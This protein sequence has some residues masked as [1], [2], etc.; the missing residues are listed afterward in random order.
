M[1]FDI[2][3]GCKNWKMSTILL[4]IIHVPSFGV[5]PRVV[6]WVVFVQLLKTWHFQEG[7][8]FG[9]FLLIYRINFGI[10]III[11]PYSK[12]VCTKNIRYGTPSTRKGSFV[13]VMWHI[14]FC[15]CIM[16]YHYA[17]PSISK[18][19]HVRVKYKFCNGVSSIIII[20]RCREHWYWINVT[21]NIT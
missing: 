13:R 21:C 11:Y 18:G 16:Q 4:K 12:I 6:P 17:T 2:V 14:N 10:A 15:K 8:I 3:P 20:N 1:H 9:K 5:V 19:S 7:N